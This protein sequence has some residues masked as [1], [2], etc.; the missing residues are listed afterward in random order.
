MVLAIV[1]T[2]CAVLGLYGY[3][4]GLGG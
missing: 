4:C 3:L 2:V 1:P